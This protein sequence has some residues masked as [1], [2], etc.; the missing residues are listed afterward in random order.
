[1]SMQ[2]FIDYVKVA[3][4]RLQNTPEE[5]T[6]IQ[7]VKNVLDLLQKGDKDDILKKVSQWED[8]NKTLIA[9]QK[10]KEASANQIKFSNIMNLLYHIT[11][12]CASFTP[13]VEK[14]A[15]VVSEIVE[16][17]KVV[18]APKKYKKSK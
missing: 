16:E 11:R 2:P 4:D 13:E 14:V 1:M 6:L 18:K 15:D 3:V 9:S 17:V 8:T 7:E 5:K 10:I 12:V